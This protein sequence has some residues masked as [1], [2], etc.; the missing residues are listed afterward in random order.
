MLN[1]I[2]LLAIPVAIINIF[3]LSNALGAIKNTVFHMSSSVVVNLLCLFQDRA[4]NLGKKSQ[5]L[6]NSILNDLL[7]F[8]S[9]ALS[10]TSSSDYNNAFYF[11][12]K[13]FNC[14]L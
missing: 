10:L 13:L 3:L 5:N 12:N 4:I 11:S 9:H 1:M 7:D 6:L 8:N 14:L 2:E